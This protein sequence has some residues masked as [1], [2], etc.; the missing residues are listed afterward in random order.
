MCALRVR[1]RVWPRFGPHPGPLATG[2]FPGARPAAAASSRVDGAAQQQQQ[3]Q[4]RRDRRAVQLVG[5]ARADWP[6]RAARRAGPRRGTVA[7]RRRTSQD[8]RTLPDVAVAVAVAVVVGHTHTPHTRGSAAGFRRRRGRGP[9]RTRAAPALAL[10]LAWA[11][12]AGRWAWWQPPAVAGAAP[13]RP[14][15]R[16]GRPRMRRVR[17]VERVRPLVCQRRSRSPGCRGS[18]ANGVRGGAVPYGPQ[19]PT[20]SHSFPQRVAWLPSQRSAARAAAR[21]RGGAARRSSS[22]AS[23]AGASSDGA[24]DG[25][26]TGL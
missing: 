10:A 9:H 14:G 25:P 11:P 15:A 21:R 16:S 1:V 26:L 24:S 8:R 6:R 13:R 20:A 7:G 23:R 19:L 3:Q 17:F 2:P 22:A 18:S 5:G 12:G 4:Q